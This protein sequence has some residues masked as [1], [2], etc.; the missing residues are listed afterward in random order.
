VLLTLCFFISKHILL[1]LFLSKVVVLWL[2]KSGHC[3][4]R[5]VQLPCAPGVL[6]I[7]PIQTELHHECNTHWVSHKYQIKGVNLNKILSLLHIELI[8][9]EHTESKYEIIS[10]YF[11]KL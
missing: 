9:F 7:Q 3:L 4:S 11:L 8:T 10:F 6:G 5:L 1:L 2:E